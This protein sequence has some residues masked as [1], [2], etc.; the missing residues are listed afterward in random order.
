MIIKEISIKNFKSF[1]NSEQ[2]FKLNNNGEL[3]LLSGNNG[4][5][6]DKEVNNAGAI[7]VERSVARF[8]FKDASEGGDNTYN[9]VKRNDQTIM[10]IK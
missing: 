2:I 7:K 5:G 6:T 10:Q 9:V 1:G 8:D 4:N 3:I